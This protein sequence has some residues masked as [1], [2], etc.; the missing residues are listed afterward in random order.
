M[1][2]NSMSSVVV[3]ALSI[4][5]FSALTG[6]FLIQ[7][8]T[9]PIAGTPAAIIEEVRRFELRSDPADGFTLEHL[10]VSVRAPG[11]DAAMVRPGERD[12]RGPI[13]LVSTDLNVNEDDSQAFTVLLATVDDATMT[14][15]ITHADPATLLMLVNSPLNII[16][17]ELSPDGTA[18]NSVNI[19]LGGSVF[20]TTINLGAWR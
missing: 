14:V 1:T 6:V 20:S 4:D 15:A 12:Q 3:A 17:R 2:L 9:P 8:G 5:V 19:D 18:R 7:Q 16:L 11:I 13:T 10:I